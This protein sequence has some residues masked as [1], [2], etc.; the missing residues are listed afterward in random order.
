MFSLTS[1]KMLPNIFGFKVSTLWYTS[2]LISQISIYSKRILQKKCNQLYYSV[3]NYC[4]RSYSL[5]FPCGMVL[6][7]NKNDNTNF[8]LFQDCYT[9]M[10][11]MLI[12]SKLLFR[13]SIS[14]LSADRLLSLTSNDSLLWVM[15][16]LPMLFVCVVV[17][18]VLGLC[19]A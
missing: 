6:E 11:F 16:V 3:T 2:L 14:L 15:T 18:T 7:E 8:T 5:L 12:N 19:C 4:R 17:D 9:V 1:T 13:S 10:L